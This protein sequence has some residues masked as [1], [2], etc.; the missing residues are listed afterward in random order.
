M[1]VEACLCRP[2]DVEGGGDVGARPVEYL[3]DFAPVVDFL[4]GHL[5]YGGAGDD[6]AVV[7]LVAHLV[8]VGVE[9]LHV[10][11]GGVLRGVALDLH[12]GDFDLQGGVG[13]KPDEVG[14]GGDLQGHQVQDDDAQGADVL[15]RGS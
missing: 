5:L 11:D 15:A 13:K 3:G 9:G 6:H 7:P 1:V 2:A 8:E 14:L 10:L 4:E 12:E